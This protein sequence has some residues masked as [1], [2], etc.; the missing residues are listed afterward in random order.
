MREIDGFIFIT[1]MEGL[2]LPFGKSRINTSPY[3]NLETNNLIPYNSLKESLEAGREFTQKRR[4][5]TRQAQISLKMAE[6]DKELEFFIE[7]TNLIV[8]MKEEEFNILFGP[9]IKG[10][11]NNAPLPGAF[12]KYNNYTPFRKEILRSPFKKAYRLVSEIQKQTKCCATV[13]EL[14]FKYI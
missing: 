14:G 10:F 6:N 2:K 5:L 12:L 11:S 9:V 4:S 1:D 13:A 7:R 3:Q 8:I